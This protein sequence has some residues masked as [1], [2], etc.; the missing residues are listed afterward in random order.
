MEDGTFLCTEHK[1]EKIYMAQ[2]IVFTGAIMRVPTL[3][4][5]G[6]PFHCTWTPRLLKIETILLR[7]HVGA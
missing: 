7:S 4:F 6:S 1:L 5:L 3:V 2:N